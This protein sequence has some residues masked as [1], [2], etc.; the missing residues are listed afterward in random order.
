MQQYRNFLKGL[1]VITIIYIFCA[2]GVGYKISNPKTTPV[3]GNMNKKVIPVGQTVGI[4][5]NTAGIL[6][7]DTSEVTDL[8]GK[9]Y[10]PAKNKLLPGDY[11]QT[12]NGEKILS[13]KQLVDK[14]TNCNGDTLI[15]GLLR[16][17]KEI[18]VKV[19]P[20]ETG[21]G[22]YKVGIWVRDDLQGLG[23]VT[24]L[25]DNR[26]MALGHSVTDADTGKNL[27]V[28]NGDIYYADIFGIEK[29]KKG[30]PGEI[31]GMISYQ[32]EN[33]V[34]EIIDNEIY[35]IYG[36]IT[37]DYLT[38]LTGNSGVEICAKEDVS[39]GTAYIQSFVSGKKE[40]YEIEITNIHNNENGDPQ[41]EIVVRDEK[42]IAL[43]GGIVQGMS[44]SPILQNGK[45]VGAVTHV[46]V[47]DPT[48][49]Y[50]IFIQEMLEYE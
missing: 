21:I 24:Y 48:K 2:A 32:K 13:K 28:A 27:S 5:I 38:K 1:L 33:V 11:I 9:S 44:G 41:M 29:G 8:N 19:A 23:T 4:Y 17:D 25:D 10:A 22:V 37:S 39:L 6:V 7:I 20:V 30:K 12:L 45:I 14:I 43:T 50:G 16:N 26:F 35:G 34:G 15:F 42:L 40:L 49:G 31:Q 3:S 18:E 36:E 47:D 46:F